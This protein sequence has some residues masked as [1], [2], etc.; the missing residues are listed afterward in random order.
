MDADGSHLRT[1][2]TTGCEFEGQP[3]FSADGQRIIYERYDCDVDDSLFSQPVEG[4]AEQRVTNAPPDG[5]TDPNV[6][7]DGRYISFVR[8]D[9][10]VEFQQ[11]LTVA[12]VDGSNQHDLLPP[13]WDIGVKHAWSPSSSRLVFTRDANPDPVTGLLAAN[14]GTVSA[15]GSDVRMLTHY[16]DGRLQCVRRL[17]LA[18]RPL[19]RLPPAGQR[20]RPVRPLADAHRRQPP[21]RDLQPGRSPGPGHRLGLTG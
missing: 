17:L 7:P 10:G 5:H 3:V 21:A 20:D 19:D 11:A 14:V 8:Y 1:L 13:S 6:S 9:Q 16:T 15:D 2:P 12:D 18:R 4:G